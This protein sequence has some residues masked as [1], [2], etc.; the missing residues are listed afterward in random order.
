MHRRFCLGKDAGMASGF[1]EQEVT[2]LL[3]SDKSEKRIL[4]HVV[5]AVEEI[6][7]K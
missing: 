2:G 3:S 1:L 5:D 7:E 4:E 6:L